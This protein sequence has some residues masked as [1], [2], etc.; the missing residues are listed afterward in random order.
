[1][2]NLQVNWWLLKF[3]KKVILW[4]ERRIPNSSGIKDENLLIN[5]NCKYFS[6]LP[7]LI[8]FFASIKGVVAFLF[9]L[10]LYMC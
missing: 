5:N 8:Q 1:M 10:L 4:M 9:N 2:L 6:A 3:A 7:L